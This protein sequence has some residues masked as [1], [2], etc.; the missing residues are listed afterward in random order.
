MISEVTLP[1]L[2]PRDLLA[3]LCRV[4]A[5]RDNVE[6]QLIEKDFYLTRLLW[7]LSDKLGNELLLKGGTLLSKVDLG[8][9]RMSEDADLVLPAKPSRQ[10]SLNVRRISR[11][12]D[13]LKQQAELI[14]VRSRHPGGAVSEK[15]AHA[16]WELDYP[17]DFGPQGFQLEISI[18]PALRSPRM[19]TLRQLLRDPLIGDYAQG[20]CWALDADEAR[21]EKVRAA[22]TRTAIRDY[23]DLDR[24]LEKGFDFTSPAFVE[25]VDLKLAEVDAAPLNDQPPSFDLDREHRQRLDASHNRDL[26][27]VLRKG[28][29]AFDLDAMLSRFNRLWGP[30]GPLR[31][32][33]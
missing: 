16:I 23:Y 9:F 2:P 11:V 20:T 32:R 24:L 22:F 31:R 17:S 1:P 13:A 19:A 21:A 10:K 30:D 6:P 27:P 14:G 15:G 4:A 26:I 29:P 3:D 5:A 25:L 8:F 7:A 33:N 18:R 12:R 28:A